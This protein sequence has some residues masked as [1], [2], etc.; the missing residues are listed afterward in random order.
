MNR[1][2]NVLVIED[3]PSCR[4]LIEE[5]L[6]RVTDGYTVLKAGSLEEGMALLACS[7]IDAILL[8]LHLPDADGIEA[9]ERLQ[10]EYPKIP[11]V[12]FSGADLDME[13]QAIEAGAQDFV[14][15]GDA[16]DRLNWSL[17]HAVIRHQVRP[18]WKP[19][20]LSIDKM[21]SQVQKIKETRQEVVKEQER[22]E[23]EI[24]DKLDSKQGF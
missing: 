15:K 20:N 19:L 7:K 2:I 16:A 6:Y 10:Y 23:K 24:G 22:M 18:D 4:R 3:E 12:V 8:D 21:D 13:K 9:V 17:R 14:R 11:A 5:I 1:H